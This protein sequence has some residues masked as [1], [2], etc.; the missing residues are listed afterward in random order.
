MQNNSQKY[1]DYFESP[2]HTTSEVPANNAEVRKD[3]VK[4]TD[5][6][7]TVVSGVVT[8]CLKLNVR[9]ESNTDADIVAVID[10]LT[11]V[12]IDM[13]DSSDEFYKICTADG[14]EGFCMKKY[15]AVQR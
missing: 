9:K 13:D 7:Q 8:D 6:K 3:T 4:E 5:Q 15:I 11:E 10:L 12:M 1:R 14:V 2:K